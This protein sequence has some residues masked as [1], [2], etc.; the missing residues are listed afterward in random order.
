MIVGVPP[1]GEW[2][3]T[4]QPGGYYQ[5]A[6]KEYGQVL[7]FDSHQAKPNATIPQTPKP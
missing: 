7:T 4:K 3:Y 1:H 2:T 6:L 5:L